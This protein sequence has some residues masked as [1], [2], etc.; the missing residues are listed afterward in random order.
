MESNKSEAEMLQDIE[1][2]KIEIE[3]ACQG[4]EYA[5]HRAET[6]IEAMVGYHAVQGDRESLLA[7]LRGLCE[8]I[9]G[10]MYR[11]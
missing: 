11:L 1:L 3:V 10:G 9:E 2:A 8:R 5:W 6:A 7:A 4:E